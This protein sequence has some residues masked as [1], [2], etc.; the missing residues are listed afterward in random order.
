MSYD[1]NSAGAQRSFDL[2]P[3]GTPVVLQLTIRPGNE[4]EDFILTRSKG[5][6]AL[7]LNLKFKII[8]GQYAK[9]ELFAFFVLDGKTEGHAEAADISRRTLRAILESVKGI[10]PTDVSEAA[11]AV[12]LVKDAEFDGLCFM[13][14]VDIEPAKGEYKAKNILGYVITP[15]M[16]EWRPITQEPPQGPGPRSPHSPNA[17]TVAAPISKPA[18]AHS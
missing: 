1:Y 7:G 3:A 14:T 12:R 13:A 16:K 18:W 15:D 5:G 17:A 2:I 4:G 11:K 10:K 8:E 6:D 9:R